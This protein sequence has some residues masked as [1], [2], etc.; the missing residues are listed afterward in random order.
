MP[1][2]SQERDAEPE[3][4]R[5][6]PWTLVNRRQSKL[7][8]LSASCGPSWRTGP[9]ECRHRPVAAMELCDNG[10][11]LGA[12]PDGRAER[13]I[14]DRF[15]ERLNGSARSGMLVH[16]S[17]A[18][19]CAGGLSEGHRLCVHAN[20]GLVR[21]VT[22]SDYRQQCDRL[23]CT[24]SLHLALVS[25]Q[26]AIRNAVCVSS[27]FAGC[28]RVARRSGVLED[29]T[30]FSDGVL[31]RGSV[32]VMDGEVTE[33]CDR[34]GWDMPRNVLR[35][36]EVPGLALMRDDDD[37]VPDTHQVWC[38]TDLLACQQRRT[39]GRDQQPR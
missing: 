5:L 8:K 20:D 25:R 17:S 26:G 2:K 3:D 10:R 12:S 39:A 13:R 23:V 37:D 22:P 29:V 7:R 6:R 9:A 31:R 4:S 27:A 15:S 16:G 18:P 28:A 38:C 21:R 11:R 19:A 1:A 32:T 30:D 24:S 33:V 14:R 34:C 35:L 36:S